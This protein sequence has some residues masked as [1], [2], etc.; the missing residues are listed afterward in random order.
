[1]GFREINKFNDALLAKQV[2]R[3]VSNHDSLC[4]KF[5]KAKFFPHC[6]IFEAKSNLG[7]FAWKSILKGRDTIQKG[8]K[9]RVGN[10][11]SIKVFKDQWLPCEGSGRVLSPPL[12]HDLDLKVAD[13][14]D[15]ELH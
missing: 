6:S 13:L 10:G 4:Y 11:R 9:W 7:S 12:E 5:F 15:H 3:L 1:M 8:M 14:M 2:W